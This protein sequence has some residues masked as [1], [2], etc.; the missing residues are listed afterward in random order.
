MPPDHPQPFEPP[1]PAG[2]ALVSG[3]PTPASAAPERAVRQAAEQPAAFASSP[4]PTMAPEG[5]AGRE[6]FLQSCA[7]CHGTRG[8][9]LS[10][11]GVD[12]RASKF[13]AAKSDE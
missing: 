2:A 12:L 8:R 13:V 9:G 6:R 5:D 11:Q 3:G 7:A 1:T 10:P 4:A